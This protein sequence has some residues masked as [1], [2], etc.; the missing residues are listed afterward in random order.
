MAI[1]PRTLT[2]I[3]A[4]LLAHACY[5]AHEHSLLNGISPS[6][7]SSSTIPFSSPSLDSSHTKS[8][9]P[10]SLTGT[11][12]HTTA[13]NNA[14]PLDITLETLASVLLI[15]LGLVLGSPALRPVRWS[16]WAG[17]LEREG[18]RGGEGKGVG[19]VEGGNP[20]RGLERRAGFL[21]IR[22]QRKE[23]ADW[24]RQRGAVVKS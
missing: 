19:M 17:G 6:L 23:F 4:L 13:T 5:S 21:D 18:G 3:G 14:L 20:F 11:V 9:T 10:H 12:A 8:S 2:I 24:V 16:V 15:C 22:A 7:P 1:L